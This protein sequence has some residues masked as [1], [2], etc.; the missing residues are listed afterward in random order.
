M[1]NPDYARAGDFRPAFADG[2]DI[3]A[4]NDDTAI[5]SRRILSRHA[6]ISGDLVPPP[7]VLK[8]VLEDK[9]SRSLSPRA[10]PGARS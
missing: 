8:R 5:A 9:R 10:A 1:R 3:R 7:T 6:M 4:G 2:F